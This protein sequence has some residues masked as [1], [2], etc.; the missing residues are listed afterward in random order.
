MKS[1]KYVPDDYCGGVVNWR[2]A[3]VHYVAKTLGLLIKIDGFPLG[4]AR[5]INRAAYE[6]GDQAR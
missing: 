1:Q 2:I 5:N 6:P 4:T 3:I